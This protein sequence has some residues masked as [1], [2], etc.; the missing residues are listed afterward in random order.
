LRGRVA[1]GFGG[2]VIDV[3]CD[4]CK[5][6]VEGQAALVF[7]HPEKDRRTPKRHI[8]LECEPRLFD[9]IDGVEHCIDL[10]DRPRV[11]PVTETTPITNTDA[12][13]TPMPLY[14]DLEPSIPMSMAE[15]L[16][17]AEV[18][19]RVKGYYECAE[20]LEKESYKEW[21]RVLRVAA[22]RIAGT[23]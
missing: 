16:A 9:W 2:N 7:G 22:A 6:P 18:R 1:L 14:E 5:K 21:A 3:A 8:C 10:P 19:G 23:P 13:D 12:I 4:R 11:L 20:R 15:L 17:D